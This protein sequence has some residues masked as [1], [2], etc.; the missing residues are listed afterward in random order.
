MSSAVPFSAFMARALYDPERGYYARRIQTVGSRGDFSTSATLSPLLGRAVAGW[1]REEAARQPG[2]RHIIEIG[3]G[4]GDL[5]ATVRQSL[6]WWQ[7]RRFQWH[8]VDTSPVLK[9]QQIQRLGNQ[10]I[11]HQEIQT[12]LAASAGRAFIY[13]NELLDAFPATLLQWQDEGWQEIYITPEGREH[14]V[15][16]TWPEEERHAFHALQS[17]VGKAARQRVELHPSIRAWMQG[18]AP[19]WQEGAMLT[20]DYGDEFPALYHRR[21]MGSLRAYL[22]QHRLTG[23]DIYQNSGRQDITADINFSDY[24]SWAQDLGWQETSWGTQAELIRRHVPTRQH[25]EKTAFLLDPEGAGHAFKH[26]IHRPVGSRHF[27]PNSPS[28]GT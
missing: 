24:R 26:V 23:S 18:W 4:T 12:A 19:G 21:P 14:L 17:W 11:W 16:L 22:L 8:I 28:E 9:S 2:I 1:L 5:M 3:A 27:S 20:V 15:A 13:H 6:G 10:V 7:R 25:D